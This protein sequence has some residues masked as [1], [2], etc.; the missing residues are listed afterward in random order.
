MRLIHNSAAL[1][2]MLLM[3]WEGKGGGVATLIS[4]ACSGRIL[5]GLLLLRLRLAL[6]SYLQLKEP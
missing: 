3:R 2:L 1:T 5:V 6:L 4:N